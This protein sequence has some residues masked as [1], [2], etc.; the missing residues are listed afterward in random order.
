LYLDSAYIAKYYL[1]ESDSNAVRSLIETA[2]RIYSSALAIAEV[3]CVFHRKLREGFLTRETAGRLRAAFLSHTELGLWTFAPVGESLLRRTGAA[4]VM[5]PEDLFLRT[6]DA[7][8]L[9]TARE[10]GETEVWTSDRHMLAA[11]P[12]F[13]LTGKSVTE[14]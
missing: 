14:T 10:V 11:A 7:V 12:H 8:H 13:G 9:M 3:Q 4:I 1:N 6:A 5:G 2:R